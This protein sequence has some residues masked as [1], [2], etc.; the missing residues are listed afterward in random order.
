MTAT[1]PALSAIEMAHEAELV[2]LLRDEVRAAGGVLSFARFM[3]LALYAPGLGYYTAGAQ[4]LGEGGDFVTAPEISPVFGRCLAT[5]AGDVLGALGGGDI[6]EIGPGTGALAEQ[7]LG[8]L[9]RAGQLPR[10]YRLLETSADLRQRQQQRLTPLGTALGVRLEWLDGLP[11]QSFRGLVVAN[12]V[13]DALPVERFRIT[14]E[15]V[16]AMGVALQGS[17][18]CWRPVAAST[19][20]VEA[21]AQLGLVLPPGF[22]GERC[23][24]LSAWVSTVTAPLSAGG[25]VLIDYGASRDELYRADRTDGTLSCFFRH[26]QHQDPFTRIG[27]QDLTAW[28]DF[29]AVADAALAAG[30][31]VAGF[32]TQAMFLLAN[33]FD[34]HLTALREASPAEEDVRI[35]HAARRLVLPTDMGERFKCLLLTRGLHAPLRGLSLRDFTHTL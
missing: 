29:T 28:V 1:L 5:Q 26:R 14:A 25:V 34:R 13:L 7:M 30:L 35:V 4:K 20:L 33:D 17:D 11:T 31:D 19:A 22:V 10:Q 2:A 8:E 32:T 24:S 23:P 27:L 15:G 6:L 21:V 9:A 12:E 18:F 3:A 16:E